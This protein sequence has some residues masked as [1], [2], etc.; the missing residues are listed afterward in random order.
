MGKS[1][2]QLVLDSVAGKSVEKD[3]AQPFYVVDPSNVDAPTHWG[4]AAK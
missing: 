4:N 3:I 2:V 1:A